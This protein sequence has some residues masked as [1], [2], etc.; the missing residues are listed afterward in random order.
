M[1]YILKAISEGKRLDEQSQM[2]Q[3]SLESELKDLKLKANARVLDA[4]CGSG[5]LCRLLEE[6]FP[7]AFINGCDL[8]S[9]RLRYAEDHTKNKKT[10]Y[11][12]Q[13]ISKDF[14]EKYD[15]IINRLVGHHLD[16][17][18]IREVISNFHSNLN[19]H[20]Q[21]VII[22]IDGLFLNL[23]TLSDSLNSKINQVKSAFTGDLNISR[24]LPSLMH[25]AGFKNITWR[26]E[27][28]D[29]QGESRKLEV[30]Q[31]RERFENSKDFYINLFGS[32]FE[33][34]KFF[35]EYT[36]EASKETVPLFFNKFIIQGFKE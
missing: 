32:E 26:I 10:K 11:F 14:P 5:V 17:S 34:K 9:D 36:T 12:H 33:A 13:D 6:K 30:Q 3:F 21:L 16:R 22:D 4:G 18:K 29:F 25:E 23:G 24:Y 15:C 35:K 7:T 19:P 27:A 8:S 20:G 2:E 31:W 28:K 1:S